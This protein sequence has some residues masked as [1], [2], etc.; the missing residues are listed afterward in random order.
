M[1]S[2]RQSRQYSKG[3]PSPRINLGSSVENL[4]PAQRKGLPRSPSSTS[5]SED[6]RASKSLKIKKLPSQPLPSPKLP[7][8]SNDL[9]RPIER[10]APGD[11][12]IIHHAAHAN[13]E[14]IEINRRKSQFYEA[15]FT[16][17]DN[18]GQVSDR[19]AKDSVVMAELKTNVI[20]CSDGLS[21]IA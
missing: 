12:S 17:R 2:S 19:L 21:S 20:V 10:G 5:S 11:A 3:K 1:D 16:S 8:E 4:S 15:A 7:K 9:L 18:P 6:E 13:Q 14:Q